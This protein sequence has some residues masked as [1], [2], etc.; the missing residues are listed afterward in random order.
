ML[1]SPKLNDVRRPW[2][3]DAGEVLTPPLQRLP[4]GVAVLM[5]IVHGLDAAGHM[6]QDSLSDIRPYLQAGEPTAHG[7]ADVMQAPFRHRLGCGVCL[8]SHPEDVPVELK[9]QLVESG[10]R[11]VTTAAGGKYK[12]AVQS[13]SFVPCQEP[14]RQCWQ[15]D[16]VK[17]SRLH[18]AGRN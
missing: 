16:L 7:S 11:A 8:L 6:S 15:R 18:S 17:F 5:P 2:I 14:I 13:D 12:R 4:L 3:E 10:D 9:L 1:S